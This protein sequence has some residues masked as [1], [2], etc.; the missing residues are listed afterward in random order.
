MNSVVSVYL[1][2]VKVIINRNNVSFMYN[3]LLC[4]VM[5]CYVMLSITGDIHYFLLVC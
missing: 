2:K 4:Y 3:I 5:L 1:N